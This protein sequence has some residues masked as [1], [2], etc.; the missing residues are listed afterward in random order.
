M[1]N[2]EMWKPQFSILHSSF[3]LVPCLYATASAAILF[4]A[5]S[6]GKSTID[7]KGEWRMKKCGS[8]SSPFS[9]LHSL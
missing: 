3:S 7:L 4:N 6:F 8:H 2:E 9:I 5:N 1:E